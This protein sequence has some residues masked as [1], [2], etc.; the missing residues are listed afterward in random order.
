M[1]VD[2]LAVGE[3]E[4]CHDLGKDSPRLLIRRLECSRGDVERLVLTSPVAL[5]VDGAFTC[6]SGR[7]GSSP[8]PGVAA[9][10]RPRAT[11]AQRR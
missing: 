3:A 11:S 6:E 10:P 1:L 2:L 7:G 8:T 5:N 4:Q 9:V